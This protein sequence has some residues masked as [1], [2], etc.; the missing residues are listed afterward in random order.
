LTNLTSD[1]A[2][3]IELLSS[4][5]SHSLLGHF[6][7]D[8]QVESNGAFTTIAPFGFED[9][10]WAPA[11]SSPWALLRHTLH[12]VAVRGKGGVAIQDIIVAGA[13]SVDSTAKVSLTSLLAS[14]SVDARGA[15]LAVGDVFV[16]QVRSPD[17]V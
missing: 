2:L 7:P 16:A 14:Q 3:L 1:V 4:N 12:H 15:A 17:D 13:L 11:R 9:G 6:L 10:P 8:L 5:A